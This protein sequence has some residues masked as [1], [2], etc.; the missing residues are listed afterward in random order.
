MKGYSP[1]GTHSCRPKSDE[2]DLIKSVYEKYEAIRVSS[3][4]TLASQLAALQFERIYLL[5][6]QVGLFPVADAVSPSVLASEVPKEFFCTS[7]RSQ[8]PPGTYMVYRTSSQA[9]KRSVCFVSAE[10]LLAHVSTSRVLSVLWPPLFFF[11]SLFLV[12]L[13]IEDSR[14]PTVGTP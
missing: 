2:R 5:H 11:L 1:F 8:R 12:S 4:F 14:M 10:V 7:A 9:G 3:C 13:P 6:E